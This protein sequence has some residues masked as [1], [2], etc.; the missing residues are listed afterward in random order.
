MTLK[1]VADTLDG[2]D[3]AI[4]A[5]YIEDNG[6]FR[7][8]VDDHAKNEDPNRIPK[9][10]LDSEILKRKESEQTLM[11]V[12][13]QFIESIPED[14]RELIPDLPPAQKIKWIQQANAKGLFDVKTK[15][16]IDVKRPNDKKPT[17]FE[18]LSPQQKIA[19]GYRK[20]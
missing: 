7:L 20:K 14:M 10:R 19:Q 5:L 2:M 12:A 6:K 3:D 9:S 18:G 15:E 13:E 4:K 17:N 1:A 11:E 8:D 16:P